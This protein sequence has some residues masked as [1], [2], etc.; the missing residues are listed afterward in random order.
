MGLSKRVFKVTDYIDCAKFAAIFNHFVKKYENINFNPYLEYR[1]LEHLPESQMVHYTMDTYLC[2]L[3]LLNNDLSKEY[4]EYFNCKENGYKIETFLYTTN[5]SHNYVPNSFLSLVYR[6]KNKNG[7][8]IYSHRLS[9]YLSLETNEF[10]LGH[11]LKLYKPNKPFTVN[12]ILNH[13]SKIKNYFEYSTFSPCLI[14]NYNL[15]NYFIPSGLD[16]TRKGYEDDL[17]ALRKWSEN[18]PEYEIVFDD[19]GIIVSRNK[20]LKLSELIKTTDHLPRISSYVV[21]N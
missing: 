21:K 13:I 14:K 2:I 8:E 18:Y 15:I 9:P 6:I 19:N 20:K 16:K 5:P 1:L 12:K 4:E 10:E 11:G 3:E 17:N 7:E